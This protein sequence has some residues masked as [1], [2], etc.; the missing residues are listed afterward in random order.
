MG[1]GFIELGEIDNAIRA[2]L[3]AVE[4][5]ANYDFTHFGRIQRGT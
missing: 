3:R 5:D 4:L 1:F 2:W